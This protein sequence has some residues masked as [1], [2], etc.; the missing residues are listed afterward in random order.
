MSQWVAEGIETCEGPGAL[1]CVRVLGPKATALICLQ[2]AQLLEFG[3]VL[4]LSPQAHYIKGEP[5]R[6]GIPLCWPWFAR[7]PTDSSMPQHG[8]AR[9][10]NWTLKAA[11]RDSGQNAVIILELSDSPESRRIWPRSFRLELEIRLADSVE[12]I[13]KI[14]NTGQQAWEH[15]A[16]FHPYLHTPDLKRFRVL[17]L[18]DLEYFEKRGAKGLGRQTEEA[19]ILSDG[20]DRIYFNSPSSCKL[21]R[22]DGSDFLKIEKQGANESVVWNPGPNMENAPADLPAS[23]WSEFVCVE[24]LS[25]RQL[26]TLAPG[27]SASIGMLLTK[28]RG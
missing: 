6:G 3:S 24:A 19:L 14:Q 5:I 9:V 26:E 12:L 17:G 21:I 16:A 7:H 11:R 15:Q 1:P 20:L 27:G 13:L 8:F 2:G 4:W 22:E 28:L 25:S 23:L 18:K 10:L